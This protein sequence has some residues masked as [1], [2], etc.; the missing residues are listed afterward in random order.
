MAEEFEKNYMLYICTGCD[1]GNSIDVEKLKEVADEEFSVPA[2]THEYLCGKEGVELIK[3]D[4]EEGV[5][6]I[7]IAACS[8]RVNYDTFDFPNVIVE[9][10]NLREHV[11][12]SHKPNDPK[13]QMLA[14]DY[15]RMGIVKAQ[16]ME[17]PEPYKE[18]ITKTVLVIGGGVT[19]LTSAIEAA[20]AGYDV[21][22][23]EKEAELGGWVKKFAKITPNEP[24]FR[25]PREP[26]I[27]EKIKQV[28]ENDRIKVYTSAYVEK[29][30]GQP[31]LFDVVINQNGNQEEVRVGSIVV[32]VGWEPYDAT[33]LENLGFGKYPDVITN[34]MLEEMVKENGK[35]I[36]PSTGEPAKRVAFIQCAGQR[37]PEHLPYCSSICCMVSLKQALYVRE[38]NDGQAFIFYKDM[39]TPGEYEDFYKRVQEDPGVFLTK[40]EIKSITKTDNGMLVEVAN[41]L[42]GEDIEVEVDLVVLATGMV[43]RLK[44]I[45]D[46]LEAKEEGEA[47][48]GEAGETEEAEEKLAEAIEEVGGILNLTYRKGPELPA[49]KYGFPDS[50]FICFPYET[51]R[52]AIYAAGPFRQPMGVAESEEDATGAALKAVQALELISRGAATFPR[53]GDL[54][55]PEFFLQRCTQCKRCTE[56]CPFGALDEDEKGTPK[57]NPNR[58]RRCGV[59][60]GACPER[61]ISFKNYN[62][63]M[64][65]SM[66]KS[67]YVP[68]DEDEGLRFLAFV[69]E[70]DAYPAFD[71][72]ALNRMEWH[73]DV[74]II[75]VRCLGSF[76][77]VWVADALSRGI[78]GVILIGC[79]YGDDYQCHFIKGSEL[80]NR[81]ME[82]VQETLQRLALEAERVQVV[83]LPISEYDKIPQIIQEFVER[84]E[85]EFGPNPY[86]GF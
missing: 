33:K 15:I 62:V 9:R 46:M 10:V 48:E 29:I 59:C 21:V 79:K 80:A 86:K 32:A 76:N 18:E 41:T 70:N 57:P 64:I 49:L 11:A 54:S 56:E 63:D 13:T 44:K 38:L 22:L 36:V 68:E 6:T 75:P 30:S 40:G 65:G 19:G 16:K 47:K 1:I 85:D 77:V 45:A 52:T 39:R 53:V 66:V 35:I 83:Q 2:K 27:D 50:N 67:I 60:M 51:Q 17:F 72:A 42:L 71:M 5:N 55:Y 34:V 7:I 61:I 4:I 78:D 23:V 37:D 43:S 14:E 3:K 24:P 81:R 73:P 69:C 84:I 82:N 28:M 25:E 58:C 20:N 12:W 74:R 8:P 31:G 26:D